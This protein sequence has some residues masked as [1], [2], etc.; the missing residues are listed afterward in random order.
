MTEYSIKENSWIAKIAAKK[1]RS[2][3]VA[4]VVGKTIHL[5]KTSK[6][7]FLQNERWLKHELCHIKQFQENGYLLFIAKYLWESIKNGYHNNKYEVEA[8]EAEDN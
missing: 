2:D 5:Y 3:K 8:R 4:I 1:L 6:K 7:Q